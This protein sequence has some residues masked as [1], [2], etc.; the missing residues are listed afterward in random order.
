MRGGQ[1]DAAG[2][3]GAARDVRQEIAQS[4]ARLH[5]LA[6]EAA[7]QAEAVDELPVP[8]ARVRIDEGR[9]GSVCVLRANLLCEPVMQV[10]RDEQ[11]VL[12]LLEQLRL[13]LLHGKK[14][15]NRVENLLLDAGARVELL[16]GEDF[17]QLF[18]HAVGAVVAVA[19][20]VAQAA[21]VPADQHEVHRPRVDAHGRRDLSDFGAVRKALHDLIEQAVHIPAAAAALLFRPVREAP[22][23]LGEQAALLHPAKQHFP[24]GGAD[25][26]GKADL[27]HIHSPFLPAARRADPGGPRPFLALFYPRKTEKERTRLAK[28]LRPYLWAPA[29][30]IRRYS[31]GLM[32]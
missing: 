12:R 29:R 2:V 32:P 30:A 21:A 25:V 24:A 16:L 15:V 1:H 9:G 17:E 23:L 27:R 5:K 8:V 10:I 6:E 11:Q 13:L 14:L 7:R 18:V 3:P 4:L 28:K 20:R 31:R 19:H 22:D 26:H